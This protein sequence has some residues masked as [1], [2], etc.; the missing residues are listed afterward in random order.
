MTYYDCEVVN[1]ALQSTEYRVPGE[2][3]D[4]YSD[5]HPLTRCSASTVVSGPYL[6]P[7]SVVCRLFRLFLDPLHL[8]GLWRRRWSAMT[9]PPL[10]LRANSSNVESRMAWMCD[11]F[12]WWSIRRSDASTE[13]SSTTFS[14]APCFHFYFPFSIFHEIVDART[15]PLCTI[16]DSRLT[17][18][19][20]T[21]CFLLP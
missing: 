3:S 20:A 19:P 14:N 18:N 17:N 8:C 12:L 15:T 2:Y 10:P 16:H 6:I 1:G 4:P 21:P 9:S 5:P 13:S 7:S 11:C